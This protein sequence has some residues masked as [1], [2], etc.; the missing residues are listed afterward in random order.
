MKVLFFPW[1]FIE[2]LFLMDQ[3]IAIF[4][5]MRMQGPQKKEERRLWK[6]NQGLKIPRI[7]NLL[8][9]QNDYYLEAWD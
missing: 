6:Q 8:P 5:N 7:F 9:E 4:P 3:N 1:F 2:N